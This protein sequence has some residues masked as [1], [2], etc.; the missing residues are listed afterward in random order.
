M[1]IP[2][3]FLQAM[4]VALVLGG[5]AA[6]QAAAGDWTVG[7]DASLDRQ[8][9]DFAEPKSTKVQ[10]SLARKLPS[11]I[12]LGG[13]FQPQI[14]T[15]GD[16][17]YNVEGTI[18]YSWKI[19]E[20]FSFGG[21]AGVGEKLQDASSGGDFPYYV[22]RLHADVAL[23]DRWSWNIISYRFRDAFDPTDDYNT[24][25]L[26]TSVSFKLDESRSVLL[27]YF[28]DWKNSDPDT[29]GVGIGFRHSF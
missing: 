25:E 9:N 11:G 26:S 29:Q 24:P 7:V 8:P 22:L 20:L 14:K 2:E 3:R 15:S 10:L 4:A 19:G 18:G 17:G 5:A 28:F 12:V 27:R 13:S 23:G 21:S 6:E 16:V 1:A